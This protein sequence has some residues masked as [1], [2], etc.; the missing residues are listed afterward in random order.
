MGAWGTWRGQSPAKT[1]NR[2]DFPE[3]FGPMTSTECPG[4]TSNV[5]SRTSAVPSGAFNATLCLHTHSL[6][7]A[8]P[9]PQLLNGKKAI[10]HILCAALSDVKADLSN[11]MLS[12]SCR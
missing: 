10:K 8:H 7:I 11:L 6:G 1:L 4:G 2:D 5:N 3:P 9:T 12:P